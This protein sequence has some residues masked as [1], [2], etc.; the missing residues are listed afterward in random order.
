M[1]VRVVLLVNRLRT[2]IVS[3]LDNIN[4]KGRQHCMCQFVQ[5]W[6]SSIGYL[7]IFAVLLVCWPDY[8]SL[9]WHDRQ[10]KLLQKTFAWPPPN[11]SFTVKTTLCSHTCWPR[12]VCN[13]MNQGCS[14][15]KG[16]ASKWVNIQALQDKLRSLWVIN[17]QLAG[18]QW[19]EVP[20]SSLQPIYRHEVT[21][22]YRPGR[23]PKE[24]VAPAV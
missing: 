17:I 5:K 24:A 21:L 22:L 20:V 7:C 19:T 8:Q 4:K 18:A 2:I 9:V 11:K 15:F 13:M 16:K 3:L 23:F 14:T 1:S 10:P 12:P 6:L